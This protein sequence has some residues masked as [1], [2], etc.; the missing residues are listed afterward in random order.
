MWRNQHALMIKLCVRVGARVCVCV[1]MRARVCVCVC[2]CVQ[3]PIGQSSLKDIWRN[4]WGKTYSGIHG[5][6][7]VTKTTQTLE[8]L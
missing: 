7:W 3:V 5:N 6:L 2:V 8:T 4:G 1:R